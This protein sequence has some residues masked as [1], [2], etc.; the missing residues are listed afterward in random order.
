[1]LRSGPA[2]D[3]EERRTYL[4]RIT[5]EDAAFAVTDTA[6]KTLHPKMFEWRVRK[7]YRK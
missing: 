7:C 5:N 4:Q 1:M 3:Y 2:R 6:V